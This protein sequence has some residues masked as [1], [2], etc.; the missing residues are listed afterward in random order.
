MNAI[1]D[2]PRP[3][4]EQ[5]IVLLDGCLPAIEAAAKH[6]ARKPADKYGLKNITWQKRLEAARAYIAASGVDL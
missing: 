5:L 3:S 1:P 2:A 6:E 4:Y